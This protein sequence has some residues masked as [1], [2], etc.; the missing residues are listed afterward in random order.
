MENIALNIE[1]IK[2]QVKEQLE[3]SNPTEAYLILR[4]IL[5]YP[6]KIENNRV[7]LD[8]FGLFEQITKDLEE[9]E[10][11]SLINKVIK[12]PNEVD[13]LFDLAYGLYEHN[14]YGVAA[15]LL[16]KA[17]KLVHQDPK[18]I[19]ELVS[20]LEALM[21]NG[22]AYKILLQEKKVIESNELCRYLLA[23]NSLMIG[24]IDESQKILPTLLSSTDNDIQ[25][26]AKSLNGMV[27]RALILKNKR[28]LDNE[29][30]R[31]WHMVLNGSLLLHLSPFGLDDG[32]FGRYSYIADS[33]SLIRHGINRLEAVLKSS[34]I[35]I[36]LILALPDRS[37]QIIALAASRILGVPFKDWEDVDINTPGLIVVYDLD[38]IGSGELLSEIADHRPG[39][40]LWT[41]ASCW[42]NPFPFAPDITT[43]LYQQ[44]VNPW[45]GG[46]MKYDK[47]S[48]K[49]T[50]TDPD[51]SND[52]DISERIINAKSD[53]NYIDDLDDLLSIIGIFKNMKD[54]AKMGISITDGRRIRQKQG[55]PVKSNRF[56]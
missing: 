32:M 52:E 51:K 8:A 39:Q 2:K 34:N 33:Y 35:K 16:T 46:G 41:H 37:S 53:N 50:V 47:K 54:E 36:P 42:T 30:L 23:F 13:A 25:F 22:E 6:G 40:I 44:N 45:G 5:E 26:M 43:Y 49:V 29:D 24:K 28:S 20:N 18:I 15:T 21:L 7:W 56:M 4:N 11:S 55:S 14:L 31:G 3:K 9:I 12:N 1:E 19:S 17:N 38:E 10:L 27:K 48:Q